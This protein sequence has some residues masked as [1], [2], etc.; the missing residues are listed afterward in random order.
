MVLIGMAGN[1]TRYDN[2]GSAILFLNFHRYFNDLFFDNATLLPLSMPLQNVFLNTHRAVSA[3]IYV[4]NTLHV[5]NIIRNK[6]D[7][8][9]ARIDFFSIFPNNKRPWA[10]T[11]NGT[12][13]RH[14]ICGDPTWFLAKDHNIIPWRVACLLQRFTGSHYRHGVMLLK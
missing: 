4:S 1:I 12:Y 7:Q 9:L 8:R 10:N 2:N 11:I 14:D 3:P 6:T 13:C 5:E